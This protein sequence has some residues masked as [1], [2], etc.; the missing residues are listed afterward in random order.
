MLKADN[1]GVEGNGDVDD[2]DFD[3]DGGDDD[4]N[5]GLITGTMSLEDGRRCGASRRL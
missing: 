4:G 2:D 1:D 5:D 3:D